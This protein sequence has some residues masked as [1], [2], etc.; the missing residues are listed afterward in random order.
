[1]DVFHTNGFDEGAEAEFLADPSRLFHSQGNGTFSETSAALGIVDT[2][3]GR[4][5]LCFDHDGDGDL[6]VFVA[7]NGG[8]PALYRNDDPTGNFLRVRLTSASGNTE[9]IGAVVRAT[10]GA[11]TQMRE[12]H[13]GTNFASAPPA[14]AH[15]GTGAATT[16]DEI[17]VE[18]PDGQI[19][20]QMSVAVGQE[21]VI[22]KEMPAAVP[23][24]A[25]WILILLFAC[26]GAGRIARGRSADLS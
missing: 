16:V 24:P 25:Q 1:M 20:T 9:G 13:A 10:I 15:F 2:G 22:S 17:R 4:G 14:I 11:V 6:D 23:G 19:T 8:A 5:V 21:I 18:W 26:V 3:Q 12:I 7:N